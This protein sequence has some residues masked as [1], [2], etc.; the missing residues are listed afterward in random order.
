MPGFGDAYDPGTSG[1]GDPYLTN[2][3]QIGPIQ[4]FNPAKIRT[5]N[6]ISYGTAPN[7]SCLITTT[8][9][10][11]NFL[12]NPN[13]FTNVPLLNTPYD[14]GDNPCF[15]EI[16]LVTNP[17]DR[18]YGLHR[19]TLRGP[20][21]INL[22]IVLAKTTAITERFKLEF[23]AEFFNVLNHVEFAGPSYLNNTSNV[24]DSAQYVSNPTFGMG[25]TTGTFRGATPRIGQVALRL[26]F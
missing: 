19:N 6:E 9:V 13:S 11:G 3:E 26:S 22:D 7:G 16:H 23:R 8:P 5:I 2:A 20:G 15:P 21:V 1:A 12:F 10:T 25:T 17:A 4:M 24:T 14:Q 18:T